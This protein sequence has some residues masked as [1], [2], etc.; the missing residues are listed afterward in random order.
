VITTRRHGEEQDT[1]QR[2]YKNRDKEQVP[3]LVPHKTI[4]QNR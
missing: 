3:S 1:G 4:R 2:E